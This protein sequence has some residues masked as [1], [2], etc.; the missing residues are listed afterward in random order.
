MMAGAPPKESNQ[1]SSVFGKLLNW[2]TSHT[3]DPIRNRK[4]YTLLV[5]ITLYTAITFAAPYIMWAVL[6]VTVINWTALAK[7][8]MHRH[9]KVLAAKKTGKTH[10]EVLDEKLNS[11]NSEMEFTG[12][13]ASTIAWGILFWKNAPVIT[14]LQS[15][16]GAYLANLG[17]VGVLAASFFL[18]REMGNSFF[19]YW[20]PNAPKKLELGS[21]QQVV[22]NILIFLA[23]F[24][25]VFISYPML[26][27]VAVAGLLFNDATNVAHYISTATNWA[28]NKFTTSVYKWVPNKEVELNSDLEPEKEE[29]ASTG[30]ENQAV[31][32]EGYAKLSFSTTRILPGF[33]PSAVLEKTPAAD[34][35][36][37]L[38]A[39]S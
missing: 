14:F 9:N 19:L 26:T 18:L 7:R 8:A 38:A 32:L 34:A 27:Y 23:T 33:G 4:L 24:V 22:L 30:A 39:R 11:A 13:L 17:I 10:E 29:R 20:D 16:S 15:F 12:L 2:F 5:P 35:L 25:N 28:I 1:K 21:A 36:P 31:A 3:W 37:R 6:A